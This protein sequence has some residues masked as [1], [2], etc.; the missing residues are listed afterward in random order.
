M[1]VKKLQSRLRFN[2]VT[3]ACVVTVHCT[4]TRKKFQKFEEKAKKWQARSVLAGCVRE[5][6]DSCYE[7]IN[8]AASAPSPSSLPLDGTV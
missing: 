5:S 7:Q 2:V 4:N 6:I 1:T 8:I 3:M